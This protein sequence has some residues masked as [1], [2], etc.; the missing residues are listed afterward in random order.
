MKPDLPPAVPG[1][2]PAPAHGRRLLLKAGLVAGA[3]LLWSNPLWRAGALV[4]G[5]TGGAS[6]IA[7]GAPVAQASPGFVAFSRAI[8]EHDDLDPVTAARI[9]LAMRRD[10]PSFDQLLPGLAALATPTGRPVP[11]AR[12]LLDAASAAGLRDL[13]MAIVTA[14]YT[15]TVGAGKT[16]VVVAYAQA[17]MYRPVADGQTVPTY[18]NY[19]PLW[20]THAPPP[21]RVS[22]PVAPQAPPPA[23]TGNPEPKASPH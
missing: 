19:G 13:T 10:F 17:L 9:E 2:G 11:A 20:W 4:V 7:A 15:G 5:A 12:V 16:A 22:A 1:T 6:A 14:W 23:T 8:T 18:C 21:V 3:G